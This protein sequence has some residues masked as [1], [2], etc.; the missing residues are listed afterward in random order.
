MKELEE[1]EE[2]KDLGFPFRSYS[3]FCPLGKVLDVILA[4]GLA[5]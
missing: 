5:S 2:A 3:P 4:S 1:L